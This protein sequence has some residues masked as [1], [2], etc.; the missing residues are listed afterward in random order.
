M[1]TKD[2]IV[3]DDAQ[4]EKIKHVRKIMPDVGVAV[5]A[6][7]FRVESIGLRHAARLVVASNEMHATGVS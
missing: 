1:N 2:L 4:G 3:D 7:T 5:F 6:R